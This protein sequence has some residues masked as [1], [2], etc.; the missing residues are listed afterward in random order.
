MPVYGCKVR[1]DEKSRVVIAD[2]AAQARNHIVE[3][4]TLT[5]VQLAE[6]V[7]DGATVEKAGDLPADEPEEKQEEL[8]GDPPPQDKSKG[9]AADKK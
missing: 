6:L 8:P 4:N 3:A 1:G 2:T 9:G 7:A 5:A